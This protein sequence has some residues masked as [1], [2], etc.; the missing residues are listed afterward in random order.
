MENKHVWNWMSRDI[1]WLLKTSLHCVVAS[2]L[3]V[4][5]LAAAA[6]LLGTCL[7]EISVVFFYNKMSERP[8]AEASKIFAFSEQLRNFLKEGAGNWTNRWVKGQML[9]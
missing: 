9:V 1:R 8:C 5:L 2:E 3:C 4:Y 6:D 7:R